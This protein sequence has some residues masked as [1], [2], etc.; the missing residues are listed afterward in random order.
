MRIVRSARALA[1]SAAVLALAATAC[2]SP[3]GDGAQGGA[4]SGGPV[5]ERGPLEE[6]V[7]SALDDPDAEGLP[8]P[9]IDTGLLVGGGPPADGIPALSTPAF[10]DAAGVDWLEDSEGVLAVE[11]D[12]D[13]RAY[14]VRIMVWHEIVDD[15]VGGEP[16]SVTYCPLCDSALGF[17]RRVGARVLDFG[18]SGLLYNSDLVMFDRQTHSLWPQ[19]EGRA[20]AGE[21]AGTELERISVQVL[22]WERWREEHPDGLVLSQDTGYERAYGSSPYPGYD[23]PDST[24]HFLEGDADGRLPAKARVVGLGSGGDAVAVPVEEIGEDGAGAF[25]LEVGGGPVV[26]LAEPGAASALDA[27]LVAEGRATARTGAFRPEAGG[28]ELTLTASGDGFTDAETG[29]AWNV[30][31]EAVGGPLEGEQLEPVDKVDTF[32]FAWAAFEP[33]TA[34]H[35]DGPAGPG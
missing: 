8:E 5:L 11:V 27:G 31:G 22:P 17:H 14:P 18:V 20:V 15:V 34:V 24:P 13:A 10:E 21:L 2:A 23:D 9:L 32:W 16:V 33:D 7:V 26:V 29:S 19:I 25:R 4:A 30:R 28:R 35:T 1:A 6:G 12:G 3:V